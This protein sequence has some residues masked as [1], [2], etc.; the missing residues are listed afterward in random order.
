MPGKSLDECARAWAASLGGPHEEQQ[1]AL[2]AI[3]RLRGAIEYVARFGPKGTTTIRLIH[4]AGR[5]KKVVVV[6]EK[7][8]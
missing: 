2:K 3:M 4:P 8:A 1:E 7:E 5:L 6:E